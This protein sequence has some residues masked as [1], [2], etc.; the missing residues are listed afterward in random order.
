MI[1]ENAYILVRYDDSDDY[2]VFNSIL[3]TVELAFL[4]K[5]QK[6]NKESTYSDISQ[7]LYQRAK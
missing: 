5:L 6:K 1:A 4:T 2:F 7:I 3:V